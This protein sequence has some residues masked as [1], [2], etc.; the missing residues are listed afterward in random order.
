MRFD[1]GPIVDAAD[2]EAKEMA[3]CW[4]R[5]ESFNKSEHLKDKVSAY[6]LAQLGF[7]FVGDR[8]APG[9]LRCSFCRRTIDM[10]TTDGTEDM[11]YVENDWDR[12]LISLLNRHSHLSTTCHFSI[13]LNGDDKRF[14]AFETARAIEPLV[15][16]GAIQLSEPNLF[17]TQPRFYLYS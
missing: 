4:K 10:F 16:A 1:R 6:Q 9:K 14:A 12:R 3:D 7:F 5:L 17:Q 11:A 15:R 2:I 13:G 8:N